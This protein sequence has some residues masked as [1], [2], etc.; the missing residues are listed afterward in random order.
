MAEIYIFEK[1]KSISEAKL[2]NLSDNIV[3][4]CTSKG[5][6][7]TESVSSAVALKNMGAENLRYDEKGKPIADNCFVSISHSGNVIA[8]CKSDRPVGIDVEKISGNRDFKKLSERF[9]SPAENEKFDE[10]PTAECFYRI[11]TAKESYAKITGE[12]LKAI[13]KGFDIFNL[14]EYNFE[15]EITNGYVVTLCEKL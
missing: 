11:W 7:K 13:V 4:H 10:N 9:F 12:G 5:K 6:I 15:T 2:S 14:P 1:P 8:V 3:N